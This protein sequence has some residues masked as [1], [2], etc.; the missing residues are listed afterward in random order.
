MVYEDEKALAFRD[1]NPV[2]PTH[3]LVIPKRREGLS[4]LGTASAE[5]AGI[6]GHLMVTAAAIARQ[7]G[8][9]DFR[10]VSN[11]GASAAQSVFHLHL[12]IIGGR[13]MTWPPG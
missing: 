2:A 7:E 1:I 6:L 12:H 4:G 9:D 3:V 10:L 8:L 11:N 5:H 13:T